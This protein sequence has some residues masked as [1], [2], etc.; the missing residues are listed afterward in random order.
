[1]A[2]FMTICKKYI[3]HL[4]CLVDFILP[5]LKFCSKYMQ[6]GSKWKVLEVYYDMVLL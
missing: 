3:F 5:D 1:M 6:I 2:C 4:I